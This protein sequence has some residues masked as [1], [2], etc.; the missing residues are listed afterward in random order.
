MT[1][2]LSIIARAKDWHLTDFGRRRWPISGAAP[3]SKPDHK[4]NCDQFLKVSK[5]STVGNLS[6]GHMLRSPENALRNDRI[7]EHPET[8]RQ[9]VGVG[10]LLAAG[11]GC[12]PG[13]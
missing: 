8:R 7:E 2:F 4:T 5:T 1:S 6:H 9:I 12:Q 13:L 3:L 11:R 10:W